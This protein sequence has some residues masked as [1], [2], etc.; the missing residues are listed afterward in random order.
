MRPK[1]EEAGKK[2]GKLAVIKY[3]GN[4]R[5][6]CLCDCGKTKFVMGGNLRSGHTH[7][8]GC[9]RKKQNITHGFSKNHLYGAYKNARIRC[10]NPK[11]HKWDSYG[12]RGIKFMLGSADEFIS[13]MQDSWF[14]GASLGRIDNNGH[15]EYGN[16][17]WETNKQQARNTRRNVFYTYAGRTLI[18][19]DWSRE[20]GVNSRTLKD[21]INRVGVEQAFLQSLKRVALI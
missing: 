20:L 4:N 3:S 11:S 1:I 10:A 15:Y 8:C 6:E 21:R 13:K 14:E 16:I 12:G 19:A 18:M 7:H 9:S 2:Y 5:W 17:R